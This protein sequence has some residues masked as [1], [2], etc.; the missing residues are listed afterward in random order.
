[1]LSGLWSLIFVGP[2]EETTNPS[3]VDGQHMVGF[4]KKTVINLISWVSM[5]LNFMLKAAYAGEEKSLTNI[6]LIYCHLCSLERLDSFC[7]YKR[8][9]VLTQKQNK[10]SI[11]FN[12]SKPLSGSPV[13][14]QTNFLIISLLFSGLIYSTPLPFLAHLNLYSVVI[15]T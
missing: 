10:I 2:G 13:A 7:S 15:Y 4:G 12:S 1:M 11:T 5:A 6:Y 8:T 3:K 14:F 9:S